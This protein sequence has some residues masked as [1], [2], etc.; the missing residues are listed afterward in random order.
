MSGINEQSEASQQMIRFYTGE[1]VKRTHFGGQLTDGHQALLA[2]AFAGVTV[3]DCLF[4]H[5]MAFEDGQV[6]EGNWDLRGRE[7]SYLGC[8]DLSGRTILELGPATGY[9]SFHMEKMGGRV[10]CFDIARGLS[11]ELLPLPGIDLAAQEK[12]GRDFVFRTQ[13]SWWFS[14]RKFKSR[15]KAV[16]GDIYRMP[17]DL[18]RFDISTLGC[19]LLHLSNP[20]AALRQVAAVTDKAIVVTDVVH[21][22]PF[23]L[24]TGC[25]EFNPGRQRQ[26]P[27]NWWGLTPGAVLKMLEILGFPFILSLI[28]I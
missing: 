7:K 5:T 21:K 9:L 10:T 22:I 11:H 14:H 1:A 8:L 13:N 19:I 27:V 24:D 6:F 4:Y 28:H 12:N 3:E 2:K 18:G 26:N 16:Y 23:T 25:Q 20:F 17:V 15:V